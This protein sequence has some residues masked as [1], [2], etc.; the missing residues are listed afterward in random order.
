MRGYLITP[1]KKSLLHLTPLKLDDISHEMEN[2]SISKGKNSSGGSEEDKVE[3][4]FKE[5]YFMLVG[6]K[7]IQ[8]ANEED[9]MEKSILYIKNARLKKTHLKDEN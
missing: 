8:F 6:N 3:C 1:K 7:I 9:N 5:K 4:N 2:I